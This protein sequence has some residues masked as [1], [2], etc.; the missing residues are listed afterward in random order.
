MPH[1]QR[2]SVDFGPT[3]RMRLKQPKTLNRMVM[4]KETIAATTPH[5]VLRVAAR[6]R[7]VPL[8]TEIPS[9][10]KLGS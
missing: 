9:P 2:R 1:G 5:L 4:P 3:P 8:L 6:R 10:E 7:C